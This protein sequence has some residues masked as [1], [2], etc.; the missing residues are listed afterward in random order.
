[1]IRLIIRGIRKLYFQIV[2]HF[3][4]TIT[5]RT[6]YGVFRIFTHDRIIGYTLFK[7]R[8]WGIDFSREIFTF[9]RTSSL[10]P[11]KITIIDLG[12]NIGVTTIPFI[13]FGWIE[14]AIAVEADEDNFRLLSENVSAN[15]LADKIFPIH[16]AV[17]ESA[18]ELIL[19]KSTSNFGDHRI[20]KTDASG[21]HSEHLRQVTKVKGDTLQNL[22]REAPVDLKKGNVLIWIDIQGHEGY[23]FKGA[24]EWL[25]AWRPPAVTEVWPYAI[26]R[27]GMSLEEFT[28][29][30]SDIWG[31]YY[32]WRDGGFVYSS[33][34]E[35]PKLLASLTGNAQEDIILVP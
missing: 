34:T 21:A 13:K 27:S 31:G 18:T 7:D 2:K 32:L 19:E 15:G 1:M 4:D 30:V 3:R 23:C 5:V 17:T 6:D 22:V 29:I 12:A 28:E 25:K 33:M 24:R 11:G 35:L 20:K 10:L 8:K 14:N 9:L 26:L 16:A